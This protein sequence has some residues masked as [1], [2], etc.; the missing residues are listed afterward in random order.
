M[1]DNMIITLGSIA[2]IAVAFWVVRSMLFATRFR[3]YNYIVRFK[4]IDAVPD[5]AQNANLRKKLRVVSHSG[6]V[7]FVQAQIN[8]AKIKEILLTDY[9]L[10]AGQVVVQTTQLSGGV[11]VL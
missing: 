4:D 9:H 6:D 3:G 7:Y 10:S 8:D 1:S 2:I 11:G 5:I